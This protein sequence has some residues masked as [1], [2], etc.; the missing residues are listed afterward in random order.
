MEISRGHDEGRRVFITRGSALLAATALLPVAAWSVSAAA[1]EDGVEVSAMEELM[2]EH[3][4]L[5]RL[6]LVYEKILDDLTSE[7]EVAPET[8][9]K[10]ADLVRCY[11]QEFHEKLEEEY[12]F[13]RFTNNGS[14]LVRVLVR[15]H[16]AGR[17]HTHRIRRLSVEQVMGSPQNR[18]DLIASLRGFLGMYR[19]HKARED[20]V[21]FPAFQA[22]VPSRE[23][24]ELARTFDEKEMALFGRDGFRSVVARVEELEK[25]LGLFDLAQFTQAI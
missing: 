9:G 24:D 16:E 17:I 13:P 5:S 22:L 2:R 20:T 23:L 7:R 21:L 18:K 15:Q 10:A 14:E 11:I 3:G 6:L 1:G 25:T 19:P 12:I 8:L 4:V